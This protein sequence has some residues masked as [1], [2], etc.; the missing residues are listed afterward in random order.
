[1]RESLTPDY[2]SVGH[3]HFSLR[4]ILFLDRDCRSGFGWDCSLSWWLLLLL[5]MTS[6]TVDWCN[7][8][9]IAVFDSESSWWSGFRLQ[10]GCRSCFVVG[11]VELRLCAGQGRWRSTRGWF[12]GCMDGRL[13][14]MWGWM[15]DGW[16]NEWVTKNWLERRVGKWFRWRVGKYGQINFIHSRERWWMEPGTGGWPCAVNP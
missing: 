16:T 4:G 2:R 5:W 3:L 6:W 1:M 13:A 7:K 9:C 12:C 11:R 15:P 14:Y 8:Y 10:V